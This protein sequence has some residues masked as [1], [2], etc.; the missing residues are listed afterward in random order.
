MPATIILSGVVGS[1]PIMCAII[2]GAAALVVALT[3]LV[4]LATDPRH[5]ARRTRHAAHRAGATSVPRQIASS[6]QHALV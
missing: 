6:D 2:G 3:I 4:A 1:W 5:H